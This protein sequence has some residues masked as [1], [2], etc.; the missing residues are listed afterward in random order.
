MVDSALEASEN[1]RGIA[2]KI[3]YQESGK[4]LTGA[5][6]PAERILPSERPK[7]SRAAR[8]SASTN[9]SPLEKGMAVA[10]AALADIPDVREDIVN[11]LKERIQKGEYKVN[12]SD[13]ADMM[14]RRL[15]A[16]NIR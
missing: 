2:M 6:S 13:V 12:G 11:D 9:L 14:L 16:D 1:R 3:S 5:G 10:E 15:R 7:S 4:A 8:Q